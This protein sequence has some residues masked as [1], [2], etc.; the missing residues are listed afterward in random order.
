MFYWRPPYNYTLWGEK[1]GLDENFVSLTWDF[2]MHKNPFLHLLNYSGISVAIVII[3]QHRI[4]YR[5]FTRSRFVENLLSYLWNIG[6][7]VCPL[8]TPLQVYMH[9]C[10]YFNLN[11]APT[12]TSR[13]EDIA[14]SW[15]RS[16]KNFI[17]I[18]CHRLHGVWQESTI[19]TFSLYWK[20]HS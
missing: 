1:S 15:E 4:M 14:I 13:Q 19:T 9:N 3:I 7:N 12:L 10:I 18:M 16:T 17:M 8:F 6:K 20:K 5:S 2:S 11:T